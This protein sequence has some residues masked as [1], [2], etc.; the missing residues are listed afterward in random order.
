VPAQAPRNGTV[1][2]PAKPPAAKTATSRVAASSGRQ[3]KTTSSDRAPSQASK[4]TAKPK[5][6]VKPV[7][8]KAAASQPRVAPPPPKKQSA[9]KASCTTESVLAPAQPTLLLAPQAQEQ[10]AQT[11]PVLPLPTF[12][13]PLDNEEEFMKA[14]EAGLE[15]AKNNMRVEE[16][17]CT[18]HPN[19][20][21]GRDPF[22]NAAKIVV[23]GKSRLVQCAYGRDWAECDE[24]RE[25]LRKP[26]FVSDGMKEKFYSSCCSSR[27][28]ENRSS[29]APPKA[30]TVRFAATST[31]T[32]RC[33]PVRVA[34][35]DYLESCGGDPIA[36]WSP[37]QE[38]V[39]DFREDKTSSIATTDAAEAHLSRKARKAEVLARPR[40]V[41][42]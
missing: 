22:Y 32:Y 7:V 2:A 38:Q 39:K 19:P 10:P 18:N 3:T 11:I 17:V 4:P 16:L 21:F 34:T 36:S 25:H 5:S 30:K 42:P 20:H 29:A 9:P 6:S 31:D 8:S 33:M 26:S 27:K 24:F 40:W 41:L 13:Y 28:T 35:P 12:Q 23:D 37:S 1:S 14:V 15:R